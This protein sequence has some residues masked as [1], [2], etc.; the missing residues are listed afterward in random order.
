MLHH[1]Y[2]EENRMEK[3]LENILKFYELNTEPQVGN[4]D[5]HSILT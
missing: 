1:F 4:T 3:N 2:F 5:R